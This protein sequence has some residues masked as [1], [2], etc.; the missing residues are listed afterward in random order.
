CEIYYPLPLHLQEC[1]QFL[2]HEKGDFPTSETA[3]SEVMALPMFPE[4]TAE[5]QKRVISV[6]ASFLRQKVRKV[7]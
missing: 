7:A 1:L 4:I 6:C 2:G 5:Q 3:C